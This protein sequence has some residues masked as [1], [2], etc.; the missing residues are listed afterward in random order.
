MKKSFVSVVSM[1]LLALLATAQN[2]V[3]YSVP[4]E[5]EVTGTMERILNYVD[6]STPAVLVDKTS[7]QEV[8]DLK[9]IDSNTEIKKGKYKLVCYEWGVTY[10]AMLAAYNVTGDRRYKDYLE[11]RLNFLGNVSPYFDKTRRQRKPVDKQMNRLLAPHSLD[12]SGALCSAMIKAWLANPKLNVRKMVDRFS[13]CVLNKQQHLAD[14]T[15]S[16]NFPQRNAVWLDDMFM[17]VPTIAWMGRY[18]GDA[19]FYDRAVQMVSCFEKNMFV[20]SAGLFRH[21]WAEE[22]TPHRFFPWA[23]ANGWAILTMCEVLDALPKD[24]DGREQVLQLLRKHIA[25]LAEWQGIN[26]FWH[27]LVNRPDTYEETSATAIYAYCFAHAVNEGWVDDKAYGPQALLAWRA[28][29]S[30]VNAQGQVEGVCVG[31]G[32]GFDPNFYQYRP[33]DVMAAH[34]YGPA[35]WAGAEILRMLRNKHPKMNDAGIHFYDEE[36]KTDKAIFRVK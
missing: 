1:S 36:I 11:S 13:D 35:I 26:G 8:T 21:G 7:G 23:R 14:G 33:T 34:G 16:R 3:K 17:G 20:E 10:S 19:A 25:G 18:T 2:P 12:D 31:T 29:E 15:F 9:K 28:V 6:E 27:Q 22:M 32:M 24:Y 4:T 30:K 5:K